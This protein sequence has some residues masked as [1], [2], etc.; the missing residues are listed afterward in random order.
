VTIVDDRGVALEQRDVRELE[1]PPA[2]EVE[3]GVRLGLC[4]ALG[5]SAAA[6]F[7]MALVSVIEWFAAESL[8]NPSKV[9]LIAF[10]APIAAFVL[11]RVWGR[12][13]VRAVPQSA[14]CR[15]CG[16]DLSGLKIE[17]DGCRVCPECGG[18]WRHVRP[19]DDA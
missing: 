3:P 1:S 9:Y 11:W 16:Y 7:V 17:A 10:C 6:F 2:W 18:A 13:A 14:R 15:A 12:K 4:I 8:P 5:F 19:G